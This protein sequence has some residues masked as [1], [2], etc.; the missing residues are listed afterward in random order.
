MRKWAVREALGLLDQPIEAIRKYY[1]CTDNAVEK[2]RTTDERIRGV[3]EELKPGD[4]VSHVWT[5][6]EL[7]GRKTITL[8]D[9]MRRNPE[10]VE[11]HDSKTRRPARVIV[12]RGIVT[13]K[14]SSNSG[15]GKTAFGGDR[16][17]PDEQGEGT[18]RASTSASRWPASSAT[19][20]RNGSTLKT[21]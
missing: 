14:Q 9:E 13:R 5:Y 7:D 20:G 4:E 18:A 17:G 12:A 21:G 3:I 19:N 1:F 8:T 11:R 6:I 2:F 10:L 15:R 16:A